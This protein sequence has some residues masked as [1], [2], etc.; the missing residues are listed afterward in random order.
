MKP[1]RLRSRQRG[2][3]LRFAC[4]P[5][6][7]LRAPAPRAPR[8]LPREVCKAI[9]RKAHALSLQALEKN[10]E[11]LEQYV[12]KYR[13]DPRQQLDR[14]HAL[15]LADGR[16]VLV[17]TQTLCGLCATL[18]IL[19]VLAATVKARIAPW[20]RIPGGSGMGGVR[21]SRLGNSPAAAVVRLFLKRRPRR[22][23]LTELRSLAY[24]PKARRAFDK[25]IGQ[26]PDSR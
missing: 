4:F 11:Y 1:T 6:H 20:R 24:S 26:P 14:V 22:P 7:R 25:R 19:E 12:R 17:S 10:R 18:S 23:P 8:P 15:D 3:V 16:H 13:D 5:R 9:N 21:R 2:R